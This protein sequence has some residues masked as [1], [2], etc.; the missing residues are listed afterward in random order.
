MT[1]PGWKCPKRIGFLFPH[2]CTRLTPEGCQDCQNGQIADPYIRRSD[3]YYY[4]NYDYYDD[5]LTGYALESL[6]EDLAHTGH[7]FTEVDG[8]SLVTPQDDFETDLSGS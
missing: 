1:P 6:A 8:E 5:S 7:H 2:P 4:S 3:R